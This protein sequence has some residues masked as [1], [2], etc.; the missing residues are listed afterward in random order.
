MICYTSEKFTIFGMRTIFGDEL[1]KAI[2]NG[3]LPDSELQRLAK[4]HPK[5]AADLIQ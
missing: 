2:A 1:T 3:T 4:R 5:L